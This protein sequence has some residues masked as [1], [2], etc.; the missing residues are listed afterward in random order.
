[1]G[2]NYVYGARRWKRFDGKGDV[3][4]H[5]APKGWEASAELLDCH[6]L[7]GKRFINGR[8]E[9]WICEKFVGSQKGE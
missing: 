2:W 8:V 7:T 4:S 9:W 5:R 3:R 6:P 1:M